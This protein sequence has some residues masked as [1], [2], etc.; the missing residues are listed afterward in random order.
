MG[1]LRNTSK[2]KSS[3]GGIRD[4]LLFN[5]VQQGWLGQDATSDPTAGAETGHVWVRI[6]S[7]TATAVQARNMAVNDGFLN[8]PVRVAQMPGNKG[9]QVVDLH[10]DIYRNH[11]D[12]A[13]TLSIPRRKPEL[14]YDERVYM[15]R[16]S[17]LQL[18]PD[19]G[20]VLGVAKGY[21]RVPDGTWVGFTGDTVDLTSTV[22][23]TV[24]EKRLV[25]VGIEYATGNLVYTGDGTYSAIA[26]VSMYDE[27]RNPTTKLFYPDDIATALNT[28]SNDV[29]W[30]GAIPLI[31][32]QTHLQWLYQYIALGFVAE[33]LAG[34]YVAI[35]GDTMTGALTIDGSANTTQLTVQ[36]HSTQSASLLVLEDSSGNDLVTVSGTGAVVINEQGNDA[37][38]RV[39]SNS[40]TDALV[41]DAGQ[42]A[43]SMFYTL[44]S[45]IGSLAVGGTRTLGSGARGIVFAPDVQSSSTGPGAIAYIPTLRPSGGTLPG[46]FG[47]ISNLRVDR[48]DTSTSQNITT[49]YNSYYQ[50]TLQSTYTGT[51]ANLI[52]FAAVAPSVSGGSGTITNY[53][54]FDVFTTSTPTGTI[55]AYRSQMNGVGAY[56]FYATGTAINYFAGMVQLPAMSTTTRDT[57]TATD[58]FIVCNTTT[59]K[60]QGYVNGAWHDFH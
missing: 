31:Y 53:I 48:D 26:T 5:N 30:L 43:V 19:D 1:R 34:Q 10:P 6:G 42:D 8:I 14:L 41:V 49:L 9:Y 15:E 55:A 20:L 45:N 44:T 38:F 21:Y 37:D 3:I 24:N 36:G 4:S 39:E 7:P 16:L 60:I 47:V 12:S 51:I 29:K 22:P 46:A 17:N 58:G 11:A 18:Y 27:P 50:A 57:Y 54:G 52:M 28:L 40:A 23:G 13:G 32:G 2:I 59:N 33:S 25:F 56:G 35:S